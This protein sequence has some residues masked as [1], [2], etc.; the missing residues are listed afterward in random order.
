MISSVTKNGRSI[1][2]TAILAIILIYM[3]S[4]IG[5]MVFQDDFLIAVDEAS[6]EIP[7]AATVVTTAGG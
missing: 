7:V 4:I 1:L 3:F 5:Y 2:L 6:G